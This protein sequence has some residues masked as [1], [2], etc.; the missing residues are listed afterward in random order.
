MGPSAAKRPGWHHP[1]LATVTSPLY[2]KATP[3]TTTEEAYF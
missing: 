2:H 1:P 3:G